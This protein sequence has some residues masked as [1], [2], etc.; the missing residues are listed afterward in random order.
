MLCRKTSFPVFLFSS[1]ELDQKI[2][3]S[4]SKKTNNNRN[5]QTI[6]TETIIE[7]D[8]CLF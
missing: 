4:P 1:Y 3:I 6:E 5:L 2:F 7:G 8:E